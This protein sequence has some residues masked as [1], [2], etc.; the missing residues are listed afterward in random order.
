[1]RKQS[2][3][4]CI[5]ALLAVI[6]TASC[7][8][9]D[10]NLPPMPSGQFIGVVGD[11][12]VEISESTRVIADLLIPGC[13]DEFTIGITSSTIASYMAGKGVSN[14]IN[15]VNPSEADKN[16]LDEVGIP[17][18][19]RVAQMTA[20]KIDL[21]NLLK[22]ALKLKYT[23]EDHVIVLK[24]ADNEGQWLVGELHG[25]LV[26][27]HEEE[28]ENA[29]MT[30]CFGIIAGKNATTDGSV[31]VGHN[32]DDGGEQMLNMYVADFG[33]WAEFPGSRP[34][35]RNPQRTC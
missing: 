16:F 19:S 8:K 12:K 15:L 30:N 2:L 28:E 3:I 22:L 27:G 9:S 20:L 11:E 26:Q 17:S 32:E 35:C 13:V 21:S 5:A 4:L 33:I 23:T 14:P 34:R 1:M 10:K 18:G 31:L 6:F 25:Y 7:G 29:G 24:L